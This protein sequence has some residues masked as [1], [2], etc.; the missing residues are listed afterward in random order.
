[1]AMGL[2]APDAVD[3]SS[4]L[5]HRYPVLGATIDAIEWD[6]VLRLITGWAAGR[7]SRAVVL[8]N[9]HSVVTAR[10]DRELGQ[11]VLCADLALPDGAPV[12]WVVSRQ[13]GRW[14]PRIG[15]PDLM[16]ACCASAQ[17]RGIGIFLYGSTDATLRAL[18]ARLAEHYP[19]LRV[20][21]LRSPPYHAQSQEEIE[22]DV[23]QINAS[24]A[25]IVFVGLGCPKQ[26]RWIA[27]QHGRVHA[28]SIGVGAAFDFHSGQLRRAPLWMRKH[29]L[30]WL[31]RLISEPRRLWRRYLVTN[32]LFSIGAMRQLW[33]MRRR[34]AMHGP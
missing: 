16:L 31:H 10:R 11:A 17:A 4:Y 2:S 21:G 22:R 27:A 7:E 30:E 14:Q 8:C 25:G 29:G 24:G 5:R 13:R 32:T 18:K 12:A 3:A 6:D 26:E 19:G 33:Q 9:A 1:M 28:V 23:R 20:A 34:N 15:G